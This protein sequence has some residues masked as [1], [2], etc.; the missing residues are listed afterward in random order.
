M[1]LVKREAQCD[2][3]G[4]HGSECTVFPSEPGISLPH[5]AGL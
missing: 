4:G 3:P 5:R 2:M 1:I